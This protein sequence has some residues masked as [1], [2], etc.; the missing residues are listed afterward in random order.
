M[1]F[2]PVECVIVNLNASHRSA[3]FTEVR[4]P[5]AATRAAGR[6]L[7]NARLAYGT[8]N[9]TLAVFATNIFNDHYYQYRIDGL[10]RAVLGDPRV[11]GI[12]LETRW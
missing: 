9:W 8:R 11:F 3:I 12:T 1:N 10:P 5:Q 6:T 2:R 7:V 4:I